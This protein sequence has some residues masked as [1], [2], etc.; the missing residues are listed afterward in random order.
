[1]KQNHFNGIKQYL[2]RTL[3]R[4]IRIMFVCFFEVVALV[5]DLFH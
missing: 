1:M 3:Y 2:T 5:A 4:D